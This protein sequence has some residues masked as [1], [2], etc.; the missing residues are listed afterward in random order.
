[1][2]Y[3]FVERRILTICMLVI[4]HK[5]LAIKG[6]HHART[7]H[8]CRLPR[9]DCYGNNVLNYEVMSSVSLSQCMLQC[10][11]RHEINCLSVF[12][13]SSD[14]LC[15]IGG[16]IDVSGGLPFET[17]WKFYGKLFLFS[18]LSQIA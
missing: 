5:M 14:R 16:D 18:S 3:A 2:T 12:Y 6:E 13:H 9:F 4:I 8:P 11:V 10:S 15:K 17:G 7:M 1:M